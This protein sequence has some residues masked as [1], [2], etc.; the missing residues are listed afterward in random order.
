METNASY[1]CNMDLL[2][3]QVP[4]I[5]RRF[6]LAY[7][8]SRLNFPVGALSGVCVFSF[9]WFLLLCGCFPP[10]LCLIHL[11]RSIESFH[12]TSNYD[13]ALLTD[14]A[15]RSLGYGTKKCL[16]NFVHCQLDHVPSSTERV[17]L[18][19]PCYFVGAKQV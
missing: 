1:S 5:V 19:C 12:R 4:W 11:D 9:V 10:F 6:T 3:S 8:H 2:E 7:F 16:V 14:K 15:L 17:S 18:F 13:G